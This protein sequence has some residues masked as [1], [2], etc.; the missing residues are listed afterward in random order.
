MKCSREIDFIVIFFFNAT[1]RQTNAK[2]I[3]IEWMRKNTEREREQEER[4]RDTKKTHFM[5]ILFVPSM[6]IT[7]SADE[8]VEKGKNLCYKI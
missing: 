4:E 2:W 7:Y 1:F 6:M 8:C 3:E 5:I